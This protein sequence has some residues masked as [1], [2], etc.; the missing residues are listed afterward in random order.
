MTNDKDKDDFEL[1]E[2]SR[3]TALRSAVTILEGLSKA[4]ELR[5]AYEGGIGVIK[6]DDAN[7]KPTDFLFDLLRLNTTYLNEV[8][9]LGERYNGFALRALEKLYAF[10]NPTATRV[11]LTPASNKG[12]FTVRNDSNRG[13]PSQVTLDIPAVLD[14]GAKDRQRWRLTADGNIALDPAGGVSRDRP[15]RYTGNLKVDF[16]DSVDVLVEFDFDELRGLRLEDEIRISIELGAG[17]SKVF[18]VPLVIDN[19][20]PKGPK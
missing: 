18:R 5:K 3:E 9:K 11:V 4:K 7:P 16:G 10:A 2:T 17:R 14:I 19:R 13:R 15:T 8:A 20:P 12:S 1:L 6:D